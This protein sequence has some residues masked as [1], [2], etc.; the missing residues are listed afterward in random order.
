MSIGRLDRLLLANS[1]LPVKHTLPLV[2]LSVTAQPQ[3]SRFDKNHWQW[4][5][6]LVAWKAVLYKLAWSWQAEKRSYWL[7]QCISVFWCIF[8]E[9]QWLTKCCEVFSC[10]RS[11][12]YGKWPLLDAQTKVEGL[13]NSYIPRC[14]PVGCSSGYRGSILCHQ[15]K[16]DDHQL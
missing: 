12:L 4:T 6:V 11:L 14:I 5:S 16:G 1:A 9:E 10:K 7:K 8:I 15:G 3:H 2:S 13:F